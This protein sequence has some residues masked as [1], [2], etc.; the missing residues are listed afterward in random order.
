MSRNILNTTPRAR[1]AAVVVTLALLAVSAVVW[2]SPSTADASAQ[3]AP[4]A[5][6]VAL[7]QENADL[8][9]ALAGQT[10]KLDNLTR[11][12]AKADAER[13]A[14]VVSGEQKAAA[15]RALAAASG[16]QK[17]AAQRAAADAKAR[18]K[19]EQERAAAAARGKAKGDA[20]RKAAAAVG[21][22]AASKARATAAEQALAKRQAAAAA[23]AAAATATKP[24]AAPPAAPKAPP[25][26]E[27]LAPSTRQFGL[28]TPQSPFNWAE[29]D[30][31]A[32]TVGV[33]PTIA[34]YFQGWDGPFRADAVTRAWQ[35]GTLPLLT[36]ESQPLKASNNTTTN[37]DYS[38]PRIIGGTY[39]DYLH[40]YAR[41]IV[42]LGLP[43]AIRLDHEMNGD[44]YPWGERTYAGSSLNGNGAGDYV[45]MWR[46]VHDIFQAEGANQYVVWVW[47]P[48]IIN[49]LSSWARNTNAYMKSLYPGDEYVDWAGLSGYYRPPYAASQ[50]PTFS[51]TFDSSLKQLRSI[52]SKP[53]LLAEIGASEVGGQKAAWVT[54]LFAGLAR[55]E[56]ADII[57][58]AWFH[59]TVTTSTGTPVTNDWRI[60]STGAATQAFVEGIHNPAA[61]FVAAPTPTTPT[62]EP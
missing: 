16:E 28:Y 58:F 39:D 61:G 8:T 25:L 49:R 7:R 27:L 56:N 57:G 20:E 2:L 9:A 18:Q 14:G 55:P 1:L 48:N 33:K 19:A 40:Q 12:Q 46:H 29:F 37:P 4:S 22:A 51:Y 26:S 23:A 62:Q 35:H 43:L 53:I 15:E 59:N 47:A 13:A 54:D 41:D 32:A 17:S 30:S 34:G 11:S 52:T 45:K 36:W 6:E 44:W 10:E 21:E 38:L 31:V 60:T 24:A 3:G 50:V 5:Q 42:S